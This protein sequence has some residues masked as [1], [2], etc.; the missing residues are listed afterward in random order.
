MTDSKKPVQRLTVYRIKD[1]WVTDNAFLRHEEVA[2]EHRVEIGRRK[3]AV[4]YTKTSSPNLPKWASFFE[5]QVPPE[6]I[7][8]VSTASALMVVS[9]DG[10][11]YALAFGQ[12]RHLLE[13]DSHEDR[14]GLL[15]TL[16]TL[17]DESIKSIDKKRFDAILKQAR[18]QASKESNPVDFGID[19]EQ[20]L[21]RSITG[22]PE[23]A[24][25]GRRLTGMDALTAVVRVDL[26]ALPDLVERYTKCY[27]SDEYKKSVPWV[28]HFSEVKDGEL[29]RNLQIEVLRLIRDGEHDFVWICAPDIIDWDRVY[30]F[31]YGFRKRDPVVF[32]IHLDGLLAELKD[33][34]ELSVEWL[35]KKK[36]YCVDEYDS[37]IARWSA[38]KCLYAEVVYND[39]TYLLSGGGWYRVTKEFVDTIDNAVKQIPTCDYS[40]PIYD[41]EGEGDYNEYVCEQDPSQAVL[42]DKK[43]IQHGGGYSKIEFCDVF[44]GGTRIVHVKRYGGSGTLSHLFAQGVV[45]G[46]LFQS[47]VA[48]RE[49]VNDRLPEV[50]QLNELATPPGQKGYEIVFAIIS[51]S[52]G[53]E[54]NLPFFSR[55]GLRYAAQRLAA[56][57][58]KVS[59]AKIP[60]AEECARWSRYK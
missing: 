54:L 9:V 30:G 47:D 31:R 7:S 16:N 2:H 6:S 19:V 29:T 56:F 42:M 53:S 43:T 13:Q 45:S 18:E 57:G 28:D 25:L 26:E 17:G 41:H 38:F 14:F 50:F 20:D 8:T 1:D 33:D 37:T 21:L 11:T 22:R 5:G 60:V 4:V 39:E 3:V 12:G 58:Y 34:E 48:F 32:D 35:H 59:V 23:D 24:S 40:F 46:E 44:I 51:V 15:V 55:L 52:P 27:E 36:I 49:K 10:G